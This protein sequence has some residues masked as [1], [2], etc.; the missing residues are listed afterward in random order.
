MTIDDCLR[1]KER[2]KTR[3]FQPFPLPPSL[4]LVLKRQPPND[5]LENTY[6]DGQKQEAPI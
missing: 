2:E 5:M 1:E 4:L 3:T 6:R